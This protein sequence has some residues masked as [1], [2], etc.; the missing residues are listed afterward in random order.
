MKGGA[1]Q[2]RASKGCGT[3]PPSEQA[4][5]AV[6]CFVDADLNFLSLLELYGADIA[7]RRIP[8]HRV[9]ELGQEGAQGTGAAGKALTALQRGCCKCPLWVRTVAA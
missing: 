7:E 1:S 6:A 2:W 4:T 5:W 9:V 8:A 3:T